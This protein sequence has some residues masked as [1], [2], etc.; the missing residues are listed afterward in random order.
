MIKKQVSRPYRLKD[1][2]RCFGGIGDA[3]IAQWFNR[4]LLAGAM[5]P[6]GTKTQYAFSFAE[7]V[8]IGVIAEMAERGLT[9]RAEETVVWIPDISGTRISSGRC[10]LTTPQLIVEVYDR[11]SYDLCFLFWT[12]KIRVLSDSKRNRYEMSHICGRIDRPLGALREV[13]N[14]IAEEAHYVLGEK[15]RLDR[16][17][18]EAHYIEE[19]Q[20]MR[21]LV[22]VAN[23]T[24]RAAEKLGIENPWKRTVHEDDV[25]LADNIDRKVR[26]LSE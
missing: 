18:G 8:H 12:R 23:L 3:M 19:F 16:E 1:V 26:L 15:T 6:R 22:H 17:V 9:K 14:W 5:I 25:Y 2:K 20:G 11:L 24:A 13:A 4:G 7:V 21:T 10:Y